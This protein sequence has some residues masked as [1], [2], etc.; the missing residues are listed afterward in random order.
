MPDGAW[1][2]MRIRRPSVFAVLLTLFGVAVFCALGIWQ[3]RRAQYADRVLARFH[4]AAGAPLVSL[5]AAV[6]D[7]RAG[8]YPHV[9]VTGHLDATR[10]YLLDDAMR[11]G[12]L[13]VMVFVAFRPEDSRKVL[14][15]NLGFLA[16]R[17]PDATRLPELPP[18][19][20]H[21]VA[22][23]GIYAPPPLSGLRL[24]GN[25]LPREHTWPKQVTWIDPQEIAADLHAATYPHV[26][27]LDPEPD[28]RYVRVWTANIMS[29][30][31]HLAYAWQWFAF[32]LA[33][34][35]IF[36]ALHRVKRV[37]AATQA[38]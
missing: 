1:H 23:T 6:A 11:N 4:H 7:R 8:D 22:L 9:R 31:R 3:L 25:P 26:L 10:V 29:P 24:G 35:A 30:A 16:N 28:I 37:A 18:I 32:A 34:I 5:Q 15:V 14:L 17:P 33:A 36:L 12:Q 27:L 13:G 21:A 19:P 2:V 38:R 20:A